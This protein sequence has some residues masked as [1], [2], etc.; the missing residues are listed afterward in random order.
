M[1]NVVL[2]FYDGRDANEVSDKP[3]ETVYILPLSQFE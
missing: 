2:M 3:N 1:C